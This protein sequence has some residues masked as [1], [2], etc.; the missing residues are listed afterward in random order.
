M[1]CYLF[2][3]IDDKRM[4]GP[5][6]ELMWQASHDVALKQ[7]YLG[8][9]DAGRKARPS[10]QTPSAWA[11]AIVHVLP[12]L[13]VCVLT[14]AEKWDKMK[15]ILEKWSKQV[16]GSNLPKLSHKELL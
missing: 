1:A 9:Q 2:T 4:A 11:G 3:F 6:E 5:D 15:G 10:S 12:S 14:S 8:I 16:A 7:S 13:G